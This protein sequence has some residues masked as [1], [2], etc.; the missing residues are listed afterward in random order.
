MWVPPAVGHTQGVP[1]RFAAYA[2]CPGTGTGATSSL[3]FRSSFSGM[4]DLLS[5]ACFHVTDAPDEEVDDNEHYLRAFAL[6]MARVR[7]RYAIPFASNS[8]L[9]HDDVFEMNALV[10]GQ[11]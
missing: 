10:L 1:L 8:C 7:P 4:V 3:P 2:F 5:S 11:P 9:L 6:L